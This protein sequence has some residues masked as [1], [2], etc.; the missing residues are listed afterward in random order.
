MS[1]M[2]PGIYFGLPAE[3]YHAAEGLSSS[4]IRNLLISPLDYWTDSPSLNPNY[5][6]E[7]TEGKLIG[8]AFHHRLLEPA[9]FS[10][11]YAA[12]PS[13]EDYPEAIDGGKALAEE[14][15]RLGLKKSGTIA[16]LCERI[17]EKEPG[18]PLW[19]VIRANLLASFGDRELLKA[20]VLDDIERAARLVFA[21]PDATKALTGGYSEVSIFWRDEETGIPMKARL[22]YLKIKATVDVKSFTNPLGRPLDAAVASTMSNNRYDVQAVIYDDAV[23]AAKAMLRTLKSAAIH[24]VTGAPP[25]DDWLVSLAASPKHTFVFVFIEQGRVTN[26]KVKEFR[27]FETYGGLGMSPNEYWK[28]GRDHY[29]YGVARYVEC[30]AKFGRDKPWIDDSPMTAFRDEDFPLSMLD[31]SPR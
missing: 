15:A 8:R 18:I 1:E 13:I 14:C 16:E 30:M 5:E 21:H 11:L 29:R 20:D 2:E 25:P 12:R 19:P 10:G 27:E 24:V 9:R 3:D 23:K 31:R 17:H 28:S 6:D 26:V 4:G 7:D 22:D